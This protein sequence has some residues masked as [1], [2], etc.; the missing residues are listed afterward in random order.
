MN[1]RLRFYTASA[2]SVNTRASLTADLDPPG[3]RIE[4]Q[5]P[6]A[7][8]YS[9]C[10][11]Q[12]DPEWSV[13]NRTFNELV[14]PERENAVRA[15]QGPQTDAQAGRTRR[16]RR[17]HQHVVERVHDA[18]A[19]FSIFLRT[20]W[21]PVDEPQLRSYAELSRADRSAHC[22]EYG[23]LER[24]RRMASIT[25]GWG[26]TKKCLEVSF[27]VSSSL[28][29]AKARSGKCPHDPRSRGEQCRTPQTHVDQP[30]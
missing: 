3:P 19:R 26:P 27:A 7:A 21:G 12:P 17:S 24:R 8:S 14:W 1:A 29:V 9:H 25:A 5:L 6:G 23:Q 20:Q 10:R 16:S 13:R 22:V 2:V 30:Q 28:K 18:R 4:S 11:P 15:R